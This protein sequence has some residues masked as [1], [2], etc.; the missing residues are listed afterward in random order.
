MVTV[1]KNVIKC[2]NVTDPYH[3]KGSMIQTRNSAKLSIIYA[4]TTLRKFSI[5]IRGPL[6]WN[7]ITQHIINTNSLSSFCRRYKAILLNSLN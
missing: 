3:V 2:F 1:Q 5:N 7:G 4:K 6:F